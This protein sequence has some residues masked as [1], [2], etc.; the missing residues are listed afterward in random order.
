MADEPDAA[1]AGVMVLYPAGEAIEAATPFGQQI[2]DAVPVEV[3]EGGRADGHFLHLDG[4][5]W[6]R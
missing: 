3:E 1:D 4:R 5:R 2:G 6:R